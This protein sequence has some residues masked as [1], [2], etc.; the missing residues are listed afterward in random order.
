MKRLQQ[1]FVIVVLVIGA[2]LI[3]INGVSAYQRHQ[4]DYSHY[5]AINRMAAAFM[6]TGQLP[7][8]IELPETILEVGL[9]PLEAFGYE[10]IP[11]QTLD[12]YQAAQN[13]V[14]WPLYDE[15]QT[16]VGFLDCTLKPS[17]WGGAHMVLINSVVLSIILILCVL[18]GYLYYT[19]L[20]PLKTL[21]TYAFELLQGEL[22][23]FIGILKSP[24]FAGL[25]KGL[26]LFNDDRKHIEAHNMTLE[27]ER[28]TLLASMAHGIK[29]PIATIILYASSIE[30]GIYPLDKAPEIARKITLQA[31]TVSDL[32][33]QLIH[34]SSQGGPEIAISLRDFY[35]QEMTTKLK[36]SYEEKL[37]LQRIA[38]QLTCPENLLMHSDPHAILL[39]MS[40]LIDNAIKYGDGGFIHVVIEQDEGMVYFRVINSGQLLSKDEIPK[41]FGCFYRGSGAQQ[42]AGHGL[43]LY[44]CKSLATRL[45]GDI[46]GKS[47]EGTNE[48]VIGLSLEI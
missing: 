23:P 36:A 1:T 33:R 17:F 37:A 30:E 10:E 18:F 27:R 25:R 34:T 15:S 48:F 7:M 45:D 14:Y 3:G 21:D 41:L 4:T 38:F 31:Q 28:Q 16:L 46:Y 13:K 12:Y 24:V 44:I 26:H 40:N 29:T 8:A 5:L 9:L 47:Y 35:L 32:V 39:M 11:I 2:G 20:K 6:D 43:G 19:L 42:I 22:T